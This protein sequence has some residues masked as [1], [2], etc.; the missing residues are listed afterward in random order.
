MRS[1]RLKQATVEDIDDELELLK[2]NAEDAD[3]EE[4][5]LLA[6]RRKRLEDLMKEHKRGRFGRVYP[7][8]RQ[9]YSREVTEASKEDS[10]ND[11]GEQEMVSDE[12]GGEKP[13]RNGTGVVCFLYNDGCVETYLQVHETDGKRTQVGRM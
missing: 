13:A 9:D 11:E 5:R 6:L 1:N 2:P 10:N 12:N 7:I 3:D 8:A 4:K